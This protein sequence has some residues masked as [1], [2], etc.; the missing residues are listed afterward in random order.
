MFNTLRGCQLD[1]S[2]SR[3]SFL[4]RCRHPSWRA[5]VNQ[6]F[7]LLNHPPLMFVV[8]VPAFWFGARIGAIFHSRLRQLDGNMLEDFKVV[9]G[10][11][12]TLVGLIVGFTFS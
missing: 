6:V 2:A 5:K 10:A 12:L 11:T 9:L 1:C 3:H 7:N 8:S 4:A